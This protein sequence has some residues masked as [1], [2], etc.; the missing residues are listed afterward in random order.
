MSVENLNRPTARELSA[1]FKEV[2]PRIERYGKAAERLQVF[3]DATVVVPAQD[4]S[5]TSVSG[6]S[7]F[8]AAYKASEDRRTKQPIAAD[9]RQ[10]VED[11]LI[12]VSAYPQIIDDARAVSMS[13]VNA[14]N[15]TPQEE[16]HLQ[17]EYLN[18]VVKL[19][20]S[21]ADKLIDPRPKQLEEERVRLA[22]IISSAE[23]RRLDEARERV[24]KDAPPMEEQDRDLE[25]A[26]M[27]EEN[28][29]M[30]DEWAKTKGYD[31][32]AAQERVERERLIQERLEQQIEALL[33][34]KAIEKDKKFILGLANTL[35][36]K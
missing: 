18:I 4:T 2:G 5:I 22:G 25:L 29:A 36:K 31:P 8:N 17:S 14:Q 10:K 27:W 32:V 9:L 30:F 24:L 34:S 16:E 12:Q 20:T 19:P 35:L 13:F 6:V 11:K 7:A 23:K 15:L 26:V 33:K 21:M 3:L 28:F 1:A